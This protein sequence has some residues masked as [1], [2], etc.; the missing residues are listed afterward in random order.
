VGRSLAD[1]FTAT[2]GSEN[3]FDL[4]TG[5]EEG[6][7]GLDAG[8]QPLSESSGWGNAVEMLIEPV[9]KTHA[10]DVFICTDHAS[11]HVPADVSQ[12]FEVTADGQE[13]RGVHCVSKLKENGRQ[14]EWLIKVRADF[15]FF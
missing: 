1:R 11:G 2:H 10:V 8:R 5:E 3:I 6:E 12:V 7:E 15:I 4:M 14:Y 9:K 13:A